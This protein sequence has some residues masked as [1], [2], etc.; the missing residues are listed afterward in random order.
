M[1]FFIVKLF[2]CILVLV[3]FLK[4]LKKTMNPRA[5]EVTT[6]KAKVL[7]DLFLI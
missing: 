3:N 2:Y 6:N 5:S 1:M 4:K 7:N